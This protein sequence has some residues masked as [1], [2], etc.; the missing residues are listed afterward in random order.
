M[1]NKKFIVS[2]VL[3][4]TTALAAACSGDKKP[5]EN[6][7]EPKASRTLNYESE[8]SFLNAS[9]EVVSTVRVA[10]ADDQTERNEGLMDV[11]DLPQD[12]G[13]IFIFPDEQ[14]RSF[15][16]ANTPLS[17][18][19]I[20]ADADSNIVRIHHSTTPFSDKSLSSDNPAK[21]VVETNGGYCINNDIREGMKIRF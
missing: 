2:V 3:L 4:L 11:T 8:V 13:M 1:L 15:W 20:Y 5:A 19:I 21:Y 12:A 18:D 14:P 16:M 10:V 9:G 7:Q 17:L 6:S